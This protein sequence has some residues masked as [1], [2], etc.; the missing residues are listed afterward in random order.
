MRWAFLFLILL[1]CTIVPKVVFDNGT[2]FTIEI[3]KTPEEKAKGLMFREELPVNYGM[4][5]IFDDDAPRSFWMKNTLI[6]LD[7]IFID[8]NL[9][10]VEIKEHIPPCKKDPCQSYPSKPAKYVLEI[11][12]GVSDLRKITEG[13]SVMLKLP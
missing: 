12:S 6:P 3:A 4:L 8:S 9:K 10:V 2:T 13:S 1:A 5:F 11:N 7:M